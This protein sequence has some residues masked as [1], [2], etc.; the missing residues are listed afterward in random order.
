MRTHP[1]STL[2]QAEKSLSGERV[3]RLGEPPSSRRGLEKR[4]KLA[5]ASSR[6]GETSSPERDGLSL[7]TGTRRLSDSSRSTWVDFLMLSLRLDSLAWARLS[8]EVYT[9]IQHRNQLELKGIVYTYIHLKSIESPKS[10]K[11]N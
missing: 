9:Y 6:L 10:I 2:A 8:S 4:G 1:R 3:S 11:Q 5:S 7:K